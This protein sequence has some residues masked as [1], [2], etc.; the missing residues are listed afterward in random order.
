[1]IASQSRTRKGGKRESSTPSSVACKARR[2]RAAFTLSAH[3][4][5][6][7]R[8][9]AESREPRQRTCAE[10]G[11]RRRAFDGRANGD[12]R[13]FERSRH[14]IILPASREECWDAWPARLGAPGEKYERSYSR[15][16]NV[17]TRR[18]AG[19]IVSYRSIDAGC[20]PP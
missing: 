9:C 18:H 3:P 15:A 2:G 5:P 4:R 19:S 13:A 14:Y 8:A 16:S 10:R 7:G 1:M 20:S 11:R 17:G 12:G 6:Q